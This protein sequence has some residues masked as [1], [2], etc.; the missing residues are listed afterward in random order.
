MKRYDFDENTKSFHELDQSE[1]VEHTIYS[2]GENPVPA[3]IEM[4][5]ETSIKLDFDLDIFQ[6][7]AIKAVN[8]GN[9][10]LVVASTSAGKSVIAYHSIMNSIENENVAIYTA[11]VK[12]LAN[13]KYI[14]LSNKFEDV[15]LITGDVTTSNSTSSKC[16][17]MTA[18][19]L[20]NQLFSELSSPYIQKVKYIILDEAHYL[21]DE[22]RGVV[23]EQILIAAP[24]N[25][26]FVLL[27]ATLPNY[28]DLATWLSIIRDEPIHCIYQKKRPVPL[29]IYAIKENGSSVLIKEGDQ[30]LKNNELSSICATTNELGSIS[31]NS[32]ISRDP[33]PHEV[34]NNANNIIAKG[35]YPLLIFCL[36][37]RRCFKI[38]K[39]LNGIPE[40][41]DEAIQIFDTASE[42]WDQQTKNGPQFTKIRNLVTL[43]IG[44]HHSGILPIVRETIE[45]LFSAGKLPILVA[46]ETFALGV[47][48][49][50]KSV[51]FASLIKWGGTSFRPISAS[52]FLQMAGRAGRRGFDEH[53]NVFIFV[54]K[55]DN[56]K[57]LS[58]IVG[59]SPEKLVSRMRVTSSLILSCIRMHLDPHEFLKKSLLYFLNDKSVPYLRKKL[60]N[61]KD[62]PYLNSEENSKSEVHSSIDFDENENDD[63]FDDLQK[64]ATLLRQVV[65]FS[66]SPSFLKETLKKGRLVYIIHDGVKWGWS[67]VNTIEHGSNVNVFVS[68]TKDSLQRNIP[69]SFP[70]NSFIAS[71]KFPFTSICAISSITMSKSETINGLSSVAR[72]LGTLDAVRKKYGSVP[73]LKLD[74][75]K[76]SFNAKQILTEFDQINEILV[77]KDKSKGIK[78]NRDY[79]ELCS[80]IEERIKIEH[81]LEEIENPPSQKEIDLYNALF[82]QLKYTTDEGHVLDLKGNV[83]LSLHV[84]EPI[85]IV[86]LLFSGFFIDL[87]SAEIC[88]AASCFVES[89]PKLKLPETPFIIDLWSKMEAKLDNYRKLELELGLHKSEL[90]KKRVMYFVY[91]FLEK[92]S[93]ND[94]ITAS[95]TASSPSN[96]LTEGIAVRILK[97]VRELLHQFESA[98]KVMN[99]EP[100]ASSFI[101]AQNLLLEGSNF[102]SSLYKIED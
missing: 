82:L 61:L 102:E 25:V 72:L 47:N 60:K 8:T 4:N 74:K 58:S 101:K 88:I 81:L 38:A 63:E 7:E 45:L 51:M 69:S 86:E 27:T 95:T 46:T 54:S 6:I 56:P 48:A 29:H 22:Q 33:P 35:N 5:S 50:T 99:I 23:W 37:R 59:A 78:T 21:S 12:S 34:A 2:N 15:A 67:A 73:L 53:G 31:Q 57:V 65:S 100:L 41:G 91:M 90:P 52:E 85:P 9:S 89:Q 97:R 39:H 42:N 18:E 16:L 68:A 11:P 94:A 98:A 77:K 43:G 40:I 84:E 44:V 66:L 87:N 49:P 10:V 71:I 62:G 79:V 3:P 17:V 24:P 26:R 14:E 28:Y 83:A 20:R 55:G 92:K 64:Y 32:T 30:S 13:Q 93:L 75:S 1:I 70:Q 19:V 36:S 76:V 96:S 80:S